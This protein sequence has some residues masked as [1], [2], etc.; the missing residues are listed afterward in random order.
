MHRA[1]IGLTA[2]VAMVG[3][4]TT[5]AWADAKV[6]ETVAAPGGSNTH[7]SI[8][9]F[10]AH[11]A[12]A[13][14][15]GS[16]YVVGVDGTD[17]PRFEEIIPIANNYVVFSPEGR[18]SAYV[19]RNGTQYTVMVDGK[20]A[21]HVANGN[22]VGTD[23]FF[24]P[25]G[26]HW[27]FTTQDTNGHPQWWCDG[28]RVPACQGQIHPVF[29]VDGSR[30]A[31]AGKADANNQPILVVDGKLAGYVGQFPQFTAD[32]KH[33]VA[34]AQ[35]PGAVAVLFDGKPVVKASE[36]RNVVVAP[37]G[38][39][40]AAVVVDRND[41][42][43]QGQ[44]RVVWNGKDV[45][46]TTYIQSTDPT[47]KFSPDGQHLAVICA[48]QANV[49]TYVVADGKKGESYAGIDPKCLMYS[50]DSAH[51]VYESRVG[52][53][54]F[55]VYEG[56]ESDAFNEPMTIE[57]SSTGHHVA[58]LGEVHGHD[59]AFMDGK[60]L[61]TAYML[62][63]QNFVM[64]D[65]GA[66]WAA[67]A[68]LRQGPPT[69]LVDGQEI[70]GVRNVG[71]GSVQISPDGQYVAFQ[72]QIGRTQGLYLL[73]GTKVVRVGGWKMSRLTFTADSKHLYWSSMQQIPHSRKNEGTL[74][75]D[76]KVVA[77]Y[78]WVSNP[79]QDSP[80][81]WQVNNHTGVLTCLEPKAGNVERIV[82]TP[83]PNQGIA[84]LFTKS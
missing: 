17:G 41:K 48:P 72:G 15:Q 36:I 65:D 13:H 38:D 24:G 73:H 67:A 47:V 50:P 64:S 51:L 60:P 43:G 3:G 56:Q 77:T 34:L 9:E 23:L 14:M 7:L 22:T 68:S 49:V 19:G 82:V 37:Q 62:Q 29:S 81:A 80:Q 52:N 21:L 35:V 45:P 33:V 66:H 54:Y 12:A 5:R 57:F 42:T 20:P 10:G 44:Y 4:W 53:N 28:Q 61:L 18:H 55:I 30:Y 39:G 27:F 1:W 32:G 79:F 84:S 25:Q 16:R 70:S 59:M 2:C 40:Y 76:G 58:Y 63:H 8:S 83:D 46:N 6:A 31:Y 71:Q 69:L 78:D 26:K 75:A 11:L 74:V